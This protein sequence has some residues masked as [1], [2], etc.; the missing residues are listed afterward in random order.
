MKRA[1]GEGEGEAGLDAA[2]ACWA[3]CGRYVGNALGSDDPK[4]R[5]IR[6]GNGA[7]T[8]KVA[9][10][11]GGV[12]CLAKAGGATVEEGGEGW[13]VLPV[14][15]EFGSPAALAAAADLFDSALNNP[16]FGAL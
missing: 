13:L 1:A 10:V 4:F 12:A 15:G 2:R 14:D 3:L 9:G 5:R 6:C 7:F 8:L 11:A 16:M